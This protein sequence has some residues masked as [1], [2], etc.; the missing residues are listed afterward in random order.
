MIRSE[1]AVT[2]TGELMPAISSSGSLLGSSQRLSLSLRQ[3]SANEHFGR[4]LKHIAKNQRLGDDHLL[5]RGGL[6]FVVRKFVA[7]R[8]E[9]GGQIAHDMFVGE[10][11]HCRDPGA[12]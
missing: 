8:R 10:N 11:L 6:R 3:E 5:E 12:C 7:R 4:F 2:Y 9:I 1:A